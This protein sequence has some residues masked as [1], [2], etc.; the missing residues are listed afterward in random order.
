MVK[1]GRSSAGG[2]DSSAEWMR[3]SI[4]TQTP[5]LCIDN[6]MSTVAACFVTLHSVPFFVYLK[7]SYG[8][9]TEMSY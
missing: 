4:V 9:E 5:S 1:E 7:K 3:D 8:V 2:Q 6:I